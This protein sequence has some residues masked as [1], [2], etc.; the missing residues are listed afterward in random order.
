MRLD[1]DSQVEDLLTSWRVQRMP[2]RLSRWPTMVLAAA[3]T[4]PL[5]RLRPAVR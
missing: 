2:L 3:S 4:E 1:L 5:E